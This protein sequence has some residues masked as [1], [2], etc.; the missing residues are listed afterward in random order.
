M[1]S[2]VEKAQRAKPVQLPLR[3]LTSV[4]VIALTT[5][6]LFECA[7][8]LILKLAPDLLAVNIKPSGLD[9]G[10][11]WLGEGFGPGGFLK[12]N[13]DEM[14]LG[15][16][17]NHVHWKT[18]AQGF[19]NDYDVSQNPQSGVIRVMSIGDSFTAGYRLAQEETFS[20]QLEKFLNDKGDGNKYEVVISVANDPAEAL[21]Y[22][23]QS[24]FSFKPNLVVL[25]ITLGNDIS[26]TYV[27]VGPSGKYTL[28]DASGQFRRNQIQTL[29]FAHGLEK[30]VIPQACIDP[31]FFDH[32]L[33]YR[34]VRQLLRSGNG[35]EAIGPWYEKQYP[36]QFDPNTGLGFYLRE[37]PKEISESYEHL[38]RTLR[39]WKKVVKENNCDLVVLIFPQR[40]QV[41]N[42]DRLNTVAEYRLK[43]SCFDLN[44]PNKLIVDFCEKN[45]I[46]FIDP[47]EAMRTAQTDPHKSLYCPL[48]DMHPN[49]EGNRVIFEAIKDRIYTVL[50]E[51][52]S[53]R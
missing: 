47:T 14:V 9:Y 29:G 51:R 34:L 37:P 46:M 13:F 30:H 43:E 44:I 11:T 22:M 19:R 20:F 41:K 50:N 40:F 28:D 7:Y 27:A 31:S 45:D 21:N 36:R 1:A 8:R 35:G 52:K 32:F 48:G 49:A 42:E 5:L 33:T 25:G 18:N 39:A 4:I 17:G 12:P 10:D 24:G 6:F 2:V 38:F 3:K 16:Y 53:A 23:N 15:A 26:G